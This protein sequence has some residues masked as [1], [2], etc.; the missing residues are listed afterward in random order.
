MFPYLFCAL[1]SVSRL[2]EMDTSGARFSISMEK[3][4]SKV[5]RGSVRA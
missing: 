4:G 1:T 2:T 5:E 3:S